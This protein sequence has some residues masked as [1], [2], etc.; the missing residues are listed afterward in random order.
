MYYAFIQYWQKK[1]KTTSTILYIFVKS[2]VKTVW[3]TNTSL[4]SL[5]ISQYTR[6]KIE[7][8]LRAWTYCS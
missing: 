7:N 2:S 5:V 4:D 3:S 8:S 6:G 1:K